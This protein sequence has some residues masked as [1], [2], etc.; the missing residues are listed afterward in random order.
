MKKKH[1]R[2][3]SLAFFLFGIFLLLNSKTDITGAI[4]R[5][6]S[7]PLGFSS[8]FGIVFIL[9]SVVLFI[10]RENLEERLKVKKTSVQKRGGSYYLINKKTSESFSLKDIKE[11]SIDKHLRRELRKEY[12]SD[13]LRLYSDSTEQERFQYK[14]FIEALSP[15]TNRKDLDKRLKQFAN[16]YNFLKDKLAYM[17]PKRIDEAKSS[18]FSDIVYVR[19]EN[20]RDTLWPE[21]ESIGFLPFDEVKVNPSRG[22]L[23]SVIP[24]IKLIQDGYLLKNGKTLNPKWSSQKRQDYL[25]DK[26]GIDVGTRQ[27]NMIFFQ[28]EKDSKIESFGNYKNI[29]VEKKVPLVKVIRKK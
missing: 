6:S 20:E 7:I 13:L 26:H 11:F 14:R 12:F 27:R 5:V 3:L 21:E 1:F 24:R 22:P 19:F 25:R 29:I 28:I 18:D 4:V 16:V 17:D 2:F 8:I 9:F 23:F 15:N 10:G